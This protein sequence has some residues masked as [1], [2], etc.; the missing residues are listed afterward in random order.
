[1]GDAAP[2]SAANLSTSVIGL[3]VLDSAPSLALTATLP[4]HYTSAAA[5]TV[6]PA[7]LLPLS[8]PNAAAV[9]LHGGCASSSS[10]SDKVSVGTYLEHYC[11]C[12]IRTEKQNQH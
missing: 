11:L 10:S 7:A 4:H 5:T 9:A 6:P 1:M 12:E 3:S 2:A 8:R